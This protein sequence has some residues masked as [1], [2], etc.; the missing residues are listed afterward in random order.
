MH[1]LNSARLKVKRANVHINSLNLAIRRASGNPN[2][3]IIKE[4]KIKIPDDL[5]NTV[6]APGLIK[7]HLEP[8]IPDNWCSM[9]GDILSNLRASLDHIAW[10]LAMEQCRETGIPLSEKQQRRVTFPIHLKRSTKPYKIGVGLSLNDVKGFPE[11]TWDLIESFEPYNR[12]N[13]PK[14][15]LLGVL[16]YLVCKDKHRIITPVKRQFTFRFS[17]DQQAIR[18]RLNQPNE[19]LFADIDNSTTLQQNTE[20]DIVLDVPFVQGFY[21]SISRLSEIHNFIRD[22]VIPSFTTFFK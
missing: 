11:N 13:R 18:A 7:L 6:N 3:S 15:E 9:V 12:I 16:D 10:S 21:F 2:I 19:Y 14:T 4:G 1:P 22:E 8:S 20:F 5:K 17:G